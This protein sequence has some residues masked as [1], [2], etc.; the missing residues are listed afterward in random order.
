M[1]T[2]EQK[3]RA[4]TTR[5]GSE[6]TIYTGEETNTQDGY[7]ASRTATWTAVPLGSPADL[8]SPR[9]VDSRRGKPCRTLVQSFPQVTP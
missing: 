4:T 1:K 3:S 5:G 9:N 2:T 7:A 6:G 8:S